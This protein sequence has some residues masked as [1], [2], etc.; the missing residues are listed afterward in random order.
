METLLPSQIVVLELVIFTIGLALTFIKTLFELLQP[1]EVI[2]S[3]KVYV[4]VIFGVTEG[5]GEVEE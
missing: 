4:W 1:V 2:V 5:L 3:V